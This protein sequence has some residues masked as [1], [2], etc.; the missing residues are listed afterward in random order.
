MIRARLTAASI[1]WLADHKLFFHSKGHQRLRPGDVLEFREDCQVEPYVGIFAGFGL[2]TQGFQSLSYSPLPPKLTVGR[3]CSI[4]PGVDAH[5]ATHPLDHISTAGFTHD[6]EQVLV[7]AVLGESGAPDHVPAD[8]A[9]R[10]HPVIEHD[11]WIGARAMILPGV[12]ISTGAVVAAGS[13]VTKNVGTYEIVGGNP[14]GLI[15]RRFDADLAA[16]LLASE[17]WRYR[18]TDF[19]GLPFDEPAQFVEAFAKRRA[20]IE[21]Y[22]PAK[23]ALREMP[24]VL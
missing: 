9:A 2:C 17:W 22:E 23:V 6:P 5:L 4:A 24:G 13:V 10:H 1:E 18:F 14:A 3:Y 12:T 15:R 7:R 8:C 11:V 21:P 19:A 20:E 16:A